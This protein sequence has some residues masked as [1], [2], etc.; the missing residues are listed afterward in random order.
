MKN[1]KDKVIRPAEKYVDF[2][3]FGSDSHPLLDAVR[4]DVLS[5]QD[6]RAPAPSEDHIRKAQRYLRAQLL[7][8]A[9]SQ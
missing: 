4:G 5:D 6:C 8:T 1:R 3:K 2:T 9:P 7:K